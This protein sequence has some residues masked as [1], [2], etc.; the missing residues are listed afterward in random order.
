MARSLICGDLWENYRRLRQ[1]CPMCYAVKSLLN[2]YC[3]QIKVARKRYLSTHGKNFEL[4]S[5]NL[6]R[7]CLESTLYVLI[8]PQINVWHPAMT[9]HDSRTIKLV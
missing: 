5:K 3:C 2:I 4:L 8:L 1:I 9:P 7:E 6:L